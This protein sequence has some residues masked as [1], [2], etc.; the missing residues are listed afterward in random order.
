MSLR[1]Y[2]TILRPVRTLLFVAFYTWAMGFNLLKTAAGQPTREAA[3]FTAT[4]LGPALFGAFLLGPLHEVMHRSFS[5]V[6]PGARLA[7][8]R[9]HALSLGI[10]AICCF[11]AAE[12]CGLPFPRPASLGLI[13]ASLSFPLLNRRRALGSAYFLWM[14]SYLA[15][16]T[17]LAL[18]TRT[19][20]LDAGRA[21]PWATLVAGAAIAGLCFRRGF[22][23]ESLRERS[24]NPQL[25]CC[26]QS[27][28]PFVGS[29]GFALT[30]Y[31]QTENGRLLAARKANHTGRDWTVTTVGSSL[32]EWVAV[33]HHSR[34]G[35][36]RLG[37]H[38]L[39]LLIIGVSPLGC[40]ALIQFFIN[41]ADQQR[42]I[43]FP[44][45]CRVLAESLRLGAAPDLIS[46]LFVIF[47]L[48]FGV[49]AAAAFAI[50][51]AFQSY[52][53][54]LSRPRLA[55]CV[56]LE[57]LHLNSLV[58]AAFAAELFAVAIGAALF[59]G[60][61]LDWSLFGRPLAV[62]LLLPPAALLV[63]A[64]VYRLA[65]HRWVMLGG[66]LLPVMAGSGFAGA[67]AAKLG[68][69]A[70]DCSPV[71]LL[72]AVLTPTG[73]AV[74][75]AVTV[76]AVALNWLALRHHFRTCDLTRPLPWI[77]HVA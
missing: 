72:D 65:R 35:G 66:I 34:F 28:L 67:L 70:S 27:T 12:F 11:L 16:I 71:V 47:A 20:L 42:A 61:S 10:V 68:N 53:L 33:A 77:A 54:P 23:V 3:F 30:R 32:R 57:T 5:A 76:A 18:P 48:F 9:R 52:R 63:Q 37:Q 75:I 6:L 64:F 46:T 45:I 4:L 7:F 41:R 38:L 2:L 13:V 31:A 24:R 44:E 59:A 73:L 51:F 19:L 15:L 29:G 62:A 39:G 56:L 21:F 25:F 8:R 50:P 58:T 14:G 55:H 22:S 43:P 69:R 74:C 1:A 17:F 26:F 36:T 40:I 49:I 60:L